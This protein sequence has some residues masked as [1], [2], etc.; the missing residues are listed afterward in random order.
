M[1]DVA[2][3]AG[4]DEVVLA[5]RGSTPNGSRVIFSQPSVSIG[6]VAHSVSVSRAQSYLT[7]RATPAEGGEAR[8]LECTVAQ[9][10]HSTLYGPLSLLPEDELPKLCEALANGLTTKTDRYGAPALAL[11]LPAPLPPLC[12]FTLALPKAWAT[13][14]GEASTRQMAVKACGRE[15]SDEV[16]IIATDVS[17]G[18]EEIFWS[19]LG[20]KWRRWG[21]P[22]TDITVPIGSS[23]QLTAEQKALL[24]QKLS[25]ALR[26][27][28]DPMAR[29]TSAVLTVMSP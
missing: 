12:E 25:L 2:A 24:Q 17:T 20:D 27:R 4:D 22:L 23:P 1:L 5:E 8:V 10:I 6:G 9:W 19:R 18:T 15:G 26:T 3:V 11:D 28:S 29:T 21:A 7:I 14:T 16:W 13:G